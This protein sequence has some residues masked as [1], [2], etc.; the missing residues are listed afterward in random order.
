MAQQAY[1]STTHSLFLPLFA[2]TA[3]NAYISS[4]LSYNTGSFPV[5][6]ANMT[7]SPTSHNPI[8]IF[9]QPS[10]DVL[11][12]SIY[13]LATLRFTSPAPQLVSNV[14]FIFHVSLY[15]PLGEFSQPTCLNGLC[16]PSDTIP[17]T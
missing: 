2:I 14:P 13:T 3:P 8:H 7:S 17:L 12:T 9:T 1:L 16:P 6:T 4:L 15:T 5:A 10:L 11:I